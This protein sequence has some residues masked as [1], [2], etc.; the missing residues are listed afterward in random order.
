MLLYLDNQRSV[1]PAST[2]GRR[3]NKS[4]SGRTTGLNENL[5]REILELHTLGVDGGYTQTDVTTFSA[6]I[7]GWSIGGV[8]E[9]GRFSEGVPGTFEF[10]EAIH[11]P[12]PKTMLGKTYREK[13]IHQGV[14]VLHDLAIH[15]S[16]AHHLAAKL[17]R[18]FIADDPPKATID[19]LAS[20][21]LDSGGDLTSVYEALVDEDA[22]WRQTFT[23]YKSPHDFVVSTL[24][25]LA[26]KP[27]SPQFIVNALELMGQTPY[28]PGSPAGWPD[29]ADHWGGA[30]G[31]YKRIEWANSVARSVD[32]RINPA[33]LGSVILDDAFN[34]ET[35]KAILRAESLAQGMT[36][37]LASP[38]FQRR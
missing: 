14:A 12:G 24:R 6:V 21:Y 28:R 5:A 25:A 8:N 9:R 26:Y 35:A 23:K 29:T 1:G 27:R 2:L 34:P 15:P 11:E 13:G 36:L 19:R 32:S 4:R 20:V 16:T 10:R 3:A 38:D 30:D 7:T 18:H 33:R 22:A 17:A 31:L 37:F